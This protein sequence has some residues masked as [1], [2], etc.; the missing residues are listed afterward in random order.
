MT[1][2][3]LLTID[4]GGTT[5][6]ACII[7]GDAEI[8]NETLSEY[9]SKA[10]ASTQ[11][12]LNQFMMIVFEQMKKAKALSIPLAGIGFA[13]PGPFD[14]KQGICL[15]KG[16][17]KYESLYNVNIKNYVEA[18]IN[19][20]VDL[21]NQFSH[22]FKVM[23]NND[24]DSFA[25]GESHYGQAKL[26]K[27]VLCLTL[28]TGIGSSFVVNGKIA[29]Q[30]APLNGRVHLARYQDGFVEDFVSK[31]GILRIAHSVGLNTDRLDV[32]DIANQ[33]YQGNQLAIKTFHS[34]GHI[35]GG[36]L[37]PFVT[38]FK[39]RGIVLGGQISKSSNL[40]LPKINE[41][42]KDDNVK[43]YVTQQSLHSTLL[44]LYVYFTNGN[45]G[46]NNAMT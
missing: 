38:S 2:Y 43:I 7:N 1:N 39:P 12:I 40:F 20:K 29:N 5:I 4:V 11:V 37:V 13:F 34:F 41:Q 10:K 30:M 46:V 16:L 45:R 3:G 44:G 6:K 31:R 25:L 18:Q 36:V 19:S 23:F 14:Y 33:A 28:G 27:K 24:A 21:R 8:L 32:L 9:N 35:L 22:D 17:D 42:I 15:I 26:L